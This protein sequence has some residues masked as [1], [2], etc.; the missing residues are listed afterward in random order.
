MC[1]IAGLV[2]AKGIDPALLMRMAGSMAHR[3]PDDEGFWSDQEAGIGLAHRR[4]AILDL[5]PQG[6]Q[7]MQSTCRRYVICY[8]GEVYNHGEIRAELEAFSPALATKEE[9][10]AANKIDLATD[11]DEDAL[12][13]LRRTGRCGAATL[14]AAE[15][16]RVLITRGH[17]HEGGNSESLHRGASCMAT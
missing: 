13:A 17:Q 12:A 9:V 10:V 5:S 16:R 7:P 14:G 8:N 1:G 15:L 11:G 6:H 4:L 2:T 3:G